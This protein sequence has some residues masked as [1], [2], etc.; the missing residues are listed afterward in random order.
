MQALKDRSYDAVKSV[1]ELNFLHIIVKWNFQASQVGPH[2][3][4][5]ASLTQLIFPY[6]SELALKISFVKKVS[7]PLRVIKKGAHLMQFEVYS[8]PFVAFLRNDF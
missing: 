6:L 7:L 2:E 1:M 3:A 5:E 8:L 4:T